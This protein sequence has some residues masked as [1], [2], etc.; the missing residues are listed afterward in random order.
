MDRKLNECVADVCTSILPAIECRDLLDPN[1]LCCRITCER[2]TF[3][4]DGGVKAYMVDTLNKIHS[5]VL[6]ISKL[7]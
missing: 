3:D 4:T 5:N 2:R 6:E 1:F 7:N